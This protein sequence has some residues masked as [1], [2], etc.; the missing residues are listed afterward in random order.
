MGNSHRKTPI[1]GPQERKRRVK[2]K[3]KHAGQGEDTAEEL[4][5]SVEVIF[6][7]RSTRFMM[8]QSRNRALGMML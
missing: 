7:H 4:S 5:S 3:C 2:R 8:M 6:L 1:L